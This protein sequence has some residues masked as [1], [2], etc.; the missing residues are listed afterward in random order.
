LLQIMLDIFP[1]IL[2]LIPMYYAL[3]VIA[4]EPEK[5]EAN[6]TVKAWQAKKAEYI[7]DD[8]ESESDVEQEDEESESEVEHFQ[9]FVV[10][11]SGKRH[12]VDDVVGND[13]VMEIKHT[14]KWKTGVRKFRLAYGGKDLDDKK[15]MTHYNICKSSTLYMLDRL[16]GGGTCRTR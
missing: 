1:H 16:R 7:A 12:T 9:I 13:L 8:E 11:I 10:D 3:L 14:M 6:A 2:L 15:T 5:A 4:E